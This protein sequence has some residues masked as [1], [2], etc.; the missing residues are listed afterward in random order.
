MNKEEI[1]HFKSL[2]R[3]GSLRHMNILLD[4]RF[5]KE[6]Q[7]IIKD[8]ETLQQENEKLKKQYCERTDCSGRIGNSK[9]VEELQLKI[10]KAIE[11][12]RNHQLVFR[13]HTT[14]EI[15]EWFN[16]FYIDVLDM[17]KEV[18]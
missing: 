6:L 17:L 11:Y 10:D 2:L 4:D 12:I 15:A 5:Q 9:K 3:Q 8:Y 13:D 18:E 16:Q 1:K 7:T 14:E